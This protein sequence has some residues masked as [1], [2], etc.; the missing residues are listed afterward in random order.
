M[1]KCLSLNRL[2]TIDS[3]RWF[4][5]AKQ[6]D[7]VWCTPELHDYLKGLIIGAREDRGTLARGFPKHVLML[8]CEIQAEHLRQ[9]E[10]PEN[11]WDHERYE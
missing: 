9:Y 10:P 3:G 7:I 5:I 11:I 2:N 8:L 6:I 4:R 1:N